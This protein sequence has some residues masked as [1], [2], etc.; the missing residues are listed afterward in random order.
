MSRRRI[1]LL[2]TVGVLLLAHSA[3]AAE[4]VRTDPDDSASPLDLRRA[5]VTNTGTLQVVRFAT[6]EGFGDA[7]V[8]GDRGWF[9][10]G[11]KAAGEPWRRSVYIYLVEGELR[12]VLTAADGTFLRFVEAARLAPDRLVVRVPLASVAG[13]DRFAVWSVWKAAPCSMATPCVDWLPDVGTLPLPA[14]P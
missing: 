4:L 7:I 5:R 3:A 6:H 8:D 11:F 9:R 12:G 14:S 13:L 1:C 10:I 2:V